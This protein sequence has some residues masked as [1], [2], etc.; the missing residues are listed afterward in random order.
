M[1]KKVSF[2]QHRCNTG[3]SFYWLACL[4]AFAASDGY[5]ARWGRSR[6]HIS[7]NLRGSPAAIAKE[8]S[9]A[10]SDNLTRIRSNDQLYRFVDAGLLQ[11]LGGSRTYRYTG[12]RKY[13]Y[14]RPWTRSFVE[15]FSSQYHSRFGKKLN[16][17][18]AVRPL[19]YQ[20]G[21]NGNASKRST[22]PTGAT[23]DITKRHM[24]HA[25]KKW[26]RRVLL[27]LERKGVIQQPRSSGSRASM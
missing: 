18:S 26:M 22:H 23:I 4:S 7:T 19:S 24:S 5:A 17:S 16:I 25:E 8:N 10:D 21:L 6:E 1:F 27:D 20:N 9:M 2:V 12:N 14:S 15:R 3:K 11:R 13:S